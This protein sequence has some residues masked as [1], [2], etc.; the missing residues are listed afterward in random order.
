MKDNR[1]GYTQMIKINKKTANFYTDSRG[2]CEK[3]T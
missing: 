2:N 1:L 3:N